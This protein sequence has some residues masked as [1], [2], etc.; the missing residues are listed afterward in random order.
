M[1]KIRKALNLTINKRQSLKPGSFPDIFIPH[2]LT[3]LG[4]RGAAATDTPYLWDL[5][6]V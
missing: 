2:L 6:P 1:L 3:Y 5:G 4:R